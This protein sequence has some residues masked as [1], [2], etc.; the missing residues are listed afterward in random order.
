MRQTVKQLRE[1]DRVEPTPLWSAI[2]SRHPGP[3]L[4]PPVHP[5][6]R[7]LVIVSALAVFTVA[8][9]FAWQAF[10]PGG[11][12][13]GPTSPSDGLQSYLNPMGIQLALEYPSRWYAES[14]SQD[15]N[16][17]PSKTGRLQVGIVISNSV[18]AMP[19]GSTTVSSPAPLPANPD[20]PMDFVTVT[21][22]ANDD[23]IGSSVEDSTLPLLM[24]VA[25]VAPGPENVRILDAVIAGTP[26]QITV[27]AGPNSSKGDLA[28][29]DAI[30]ASIRPSSGI[31]RSVAPSPSDASSNPFDR[32]DLKHVHVVPQRVVSSSPDLLIVE[33]PIGKVRWKLD[34]GCG[35]TGAPVGG[36]SAG[37]FGG[38]G[39]D[40]GAL[41]A[42]LG[43]LN[44]ERT[45]YDVIRGHAYFGQE[46]TVRAT[47]VDGTTTDV[48]TLDGMWMIV[49]QSNPELY[50]PASKVAT[51][52]AISSTGQVLDRSKVP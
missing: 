14:V 29:A 22:L 47:F 17:D 12:S 50:S 49:F 3:E 52:E 28:A 39:C 21:I 19:S 38:G 31:E 1:F 24:D 23:A 48:V 45:F 51:V 11:S 26:I 27:A 9:A 10:Q 30:V 34:K 2:E 15:S 46:V 13:T 8:G 40:G 4:P 16:L 41:S 36:A 5:I 43:G 25:K 44:V 35:V 32:P 42:N 18:E 20:L 37:G 7:A 33:A 6:R